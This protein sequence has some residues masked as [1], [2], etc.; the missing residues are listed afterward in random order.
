VGYSRCKCLCFLSI[1]IRN[2]FSLDTGCRGVY[3]GSCKL[4]FCIIL[5]EN[6]FFILMHNWVVQIWTSVGFG[7]FS[8]VNF[9]ECGWAM[10]LKPERLR[11]HWSNTAPCSKYPGTL[12]RNSNYLYHMAVKRW[13]QWGRDDAGPMFLHGYSLQRT[14]WFLVQGPVKIVHLSIKHLSLPLPFI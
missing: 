14:L 7:H 10:C 12:V 11:C 5:W 2:M 3:S 9:T 8:G 1:I 4:V 6:K 13:K